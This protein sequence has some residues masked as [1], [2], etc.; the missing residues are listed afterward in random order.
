MQSFHFSFTPIKQIL[1]ALCVTLFTAAFGVHSLP[2]QLLPTH[3]WQPINNG[4][5]GGV[6]RNLL[7]SNNVLFA[8]LENAGVFRSADNGATWESVNAG[9]PHNIS[10]VSLLSSAVHGATTFVFLATDRGLFRSADNGMTWRDCSVGLPSTPD[11]NGVA[12]FGVGYVF[13]SERALGQALLFCTYSGGVYRS[14]DG[15]A[16]WQTSN[17]G[18]PIT[19]RPDGSRA[20]TPTINFAA[21]GDTVIVGTQDG[22]F[23]SRDAGRTWSALNDG[24]EFYNENTRQTEQERNVF[25]MSSNMNG[26]IMLMMFGNSNQYRWDNV[27]KR[28]QRFRHNIF[29]QSYGALGSRIFAAASSLGVYRSLD[30]GATMT[31]VNVGLDYRLSGGLVYA[32]VGNERTQTVFVGTVNGVFRSMDGGETWQLSS[33]GMN[34]INFRDVLADAERNVVLATGGDDFRARIFRS[35]DGGASWSSV[36]TEQTFKRQDNATVSIGAIRTFVRHGNSYFAAATGLIRSDDNGATWRFA[37]EN[38]TVGAFQTPTVEALCS[39]GS[40][41]LAGTLPAGIMRSLDNGVTWEII[42]RGMNI[43][44]FNWITHIEQTPRSVFAVQHNSVNGG[45]LY[46]S[47]DN[48]ASWERTNGVPSGEYV[49]GLA[50]NGD[51]VW[52]AM[53]KQGI[54]RSADNGQTWHRVGNGTEQGAANSLLTKAVPIS[55]VHS[56][57]SLGGALYLCVF[58]TD[59]EKLYRSLNGG[60]TWERF[61]AGL[62]SV[63]YVSAVGGDGNIVVLGTTS[64]MYRLQTSTTSVRENATDPAPMRVLPNPVQQQGTLS[65]SLPNAARVRVSLVNALGQQMCCLHDMMRDAGNHTFSF[66][67]SDIPA[68]TYSLLVETGKERRSVV[69]LVVQ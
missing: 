40:V 41:L 53:Q 46:R 50:T 11:F 44:S 29:V 22:V 36:F 39:R 3:R 26:T 5:E 10:F 43:G 48:G 8:S 49:A 62:A 13:G 4:I 7:V 54:M 47:S 18:I 45:G 16:T 65:Y 6:V 2:A 42:T 61:D 68:G 35:T 63:G 55:R 15:G 67:T 14:E 37:N 27:M 58:G 33:K 52:V 24:L 30:N 32:V 38:F 25:S 60:I 64:G 56:L 20:P 34:G 23:A 57:R 12:R 31:A 28:W 17:I 21:L 66:D 19:T 59:G 1:R 51:T 69:M 9:L